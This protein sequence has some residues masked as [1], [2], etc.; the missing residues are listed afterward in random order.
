MIGPFGLLF[1]NGCDIA[2]RHFLNCFMYFRPAIG[3]ERAQGVK[4]QFR[5]E[6]S[7]QRAEVKHIAARPMNK[8]QRLN[9]RITGFDAHKRRP[10]PIHGHIVGG[11]CIDHGRH[12]QITLGDNDIR[13]E[14]QGRCLEQGGK[15]Q[16]R[17]VFFSDFGEQ[18]HRRQRMTSKIEEIRVR[19]RLADAQKV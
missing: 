18:A 1:E 2:G 3:A 8:I 7:G 6:I 5:I 14:A 10:F 17:S 4:W 15:R 13:Q 19:F 11:R 16:V 9:R 12:H